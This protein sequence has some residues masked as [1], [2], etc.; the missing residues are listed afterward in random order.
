MYVYGL[1]YFGSLKVKQTQYSGVGSGGGGGGG[2]GGGRGGGG[3]GYVCA[4]PTFK[5]I[6]YFP[7]ELYVYIALTNN[8]LAFFIYQLIIL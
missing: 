1:I 3:G 7:L 2:G 4:P 6:F 8:Y 5:P